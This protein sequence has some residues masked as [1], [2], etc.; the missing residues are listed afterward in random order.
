M[1]RAA[2]ALLAGLALAALAD[3]APAREAIDVHERFGVRQ[4]HTVYYDLTTCKK[5]QFIRLNGVFVQYRRS[6]RARKVSEAHIRAVERGRKCD[7]VT[8][9][10]KHRFG[11]VHPKFGCGGRCGRDVTEATGF[12]LGWPYVVN[13]GD[14]PFV[15]I[16]TSIRGRIKTR[17]GNLLGHI[18]TKVDWIGSIGCT[19]SE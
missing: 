8:I 18:C 9:V 19:S 13:N 17:Q 10:D 11:D 2:S 16:A 5:T 15:H 1:K 7:G 12:H 6:V 4:R 14:I 3:V